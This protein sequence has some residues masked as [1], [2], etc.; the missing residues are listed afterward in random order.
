MLV[1]YVF[2]RNNDDCIPIIS[3]STFNQDEFSLKIYELLKE[4]IF[5]L[6]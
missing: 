6:R 3:N 2:S 1:G 4:Y 5:D